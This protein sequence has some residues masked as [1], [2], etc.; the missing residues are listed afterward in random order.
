M[1]KDLATVLGSNGEPEG[2]N[3]FNGKNYFRRGTFKA[4]RNSDDIVFIHRQHRIICAYNLIAQT[5]YVDDNGDY[6]LPMKKAIN[7]CREYLQEKGYV[8]V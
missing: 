6:T 5:F 7:Q 4:V 1:I 3:K 2:R 8:E